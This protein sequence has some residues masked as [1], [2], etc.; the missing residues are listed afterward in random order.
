VAQA[1]TMIY[2]LLFL[3]FAEARVLVPVWHPVY[4]DSYSIGGLHALVERGEGRGLWEAVQ[5]VSRLAHEGCVTDDLSVTA[6]NGQLFSPDHTPLGEQLQIPSSVIAGVLDALM[7]TPPRARRG[8][9]RITYADLG[10]EQ[11]GTVYERVLD[12]APLLERDIGAM[13][14]RPTRGSKRLEPEA[15]ATAAAAAPAAVAAVAAAA[16]AAT[17]FARQRTS[18]RPARGRSSVQRKESGSFYTPRGMADYLVR[19]TLGPVVAEASAEDI[20]G[21][22]VLDPAMGSGAFLVSACRFLAAAYDQA[23]ERDGRPPV[24]A[25]AR[26]A[27]Q[28]EVRRHIARQCLFGVDL[29][30]M[31]VQLARLSVWLT[32]MRR[33]APLTFLDHHL[34]VGD[35]LVGASLDDLVR[36]RPGRS[37]RSTRSRATATGAVDLPLFAG[38]EHAQVMRAILPAR[39]AL[40]AI[41]DSASTVREKERL[42]RAL[43]REGA[44]ARWLQLADAWCASWFAADGTAAPAEAFPAI[45]DYLLHSHAAFAPKTIE[46]W[47]AAIRGTAERRRFFHWTLEFPEVFF[48]DSGQPRANGGFD[49]IVGNP[50]WDMIRNDACSDDG[51]GGGDAPTNGLTDVRDAGALSRFVREAGLYRSAGDAHVNCYQLFVERTLALLKRGGRFGLVLPWGIAA[52]HGGARLRRRL[53]ESCDLDTL[54]SFENNRAIFPIHR[55]TRFALLTGTTG[56]PTNAV[57][58]RLGERDPTVLDTFSAERWHD[59]LDGHRPA[60]D[61]DV[62][63]RAAETEPARPPIAMTVDLLRH[64]SGEGLAFPDARTLMDVALLDRLH[65]AHPPLASPDGWHVKFGRELNVSVDRALFEPIGRPQR[66]EPAQRPVSRIPVIDGKH[67]RPFAVSLANVTHAVRPEQIAALRARLPDI[68]RPRLAFRDIASPTNRLT[69]IAAILPA[70]TVSTHT[71]SCLKSSLAL[72]AQWCLC[73]LLNSL[74]AN[75]L[76]RLRVSTHVTVALMERLPVPRPLADSTLFRELVDLA[77]TLSRSPSLDGARSDNGTRGP[78][79]ARLQACAAHAYGLSDAELRYVLTKFPLI[80][81]DTK[82]ATLEHFT[83]V[84]P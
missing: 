54:V 5:A 9:E 83:S 64:V 15:P 69:L 7:M 34:R 22:R 56:R 84:P 14:S 61:G 72:D 82:Q 23:C 43:T 30:P 60:P 47:L 2:R 81:E 18:T 57:R 11:L 53:L 41:D 50:P 76:V 66:P 62:S 63:K 19:T 45:A 48:D 8:R 37:T 67:L 32:T 65:T 10:V 1:L 16:A 55:S 33:D 73:A 31:A 29:N 52:D 17:T 38:D 24:S 51:D 13:V 27:A 25:A 42:L 28:A 3:L 39:A 26:A 40:T 4:R 46:V 68:A 75:V 74:V 21:V 49:A 6:F 36:R 78:T 70:D 59:R 71:I 79:Y 35:S 44:L 80:E 58:C 20:L 12:Y 77:L